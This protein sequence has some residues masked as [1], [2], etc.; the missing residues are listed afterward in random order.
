MKKLD[1]PNVTVRSRQGVTAYKLTCESIPKIA[2]QA[3]LILWAVSQC[4]DKNGLATVENIAEFLKGVD[5][6][7]TV[8]PVIRVIR[9]Y[10]KDMADRGL[11]ELVA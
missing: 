3:Q 4:A 10:Q 1:M 6:F 11:I 7:K 5:N 8:Q 9:H 2:P